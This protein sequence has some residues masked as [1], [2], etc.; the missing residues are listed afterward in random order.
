MQRI[1]VRLP[2]DLAEQLARL[3]DASGLSISRLVMLACRKMVSEGVTVTIPG[4]SETP[5]NE[6]LTPPGV[7]VSPKVAEWTPPP[8]PPSCPECGTEL[9]EENSKGG[10]HVGCPAAELPQTGP[11][12]IARIDR[13]TFNVPLCV[14]RGGEV[15]PEDIGPGDEHLNCPGMTRA[16]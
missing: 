4:V 1:S 12:R 8:R 3:S 9:H 11:K 14:E 16:S 7:Y 2:D 13:E 6:A 10:Q 15:S 5:K